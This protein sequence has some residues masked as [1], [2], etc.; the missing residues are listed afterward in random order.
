MSTNH[1]EGWG[2][3]LACALQ[4]QGVKKHEA[5]QVAEGWLKSAKERARAVARHRQLAPKERLLPKIASTRT[6]TL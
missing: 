5:Q 3:Y 1:I 6:F 2:D 4:M